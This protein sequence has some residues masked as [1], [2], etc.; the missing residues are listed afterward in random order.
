MIYGIFVLLTED[1]NRLVAFD[2]A[3]MNVIPPAWA[4]AFD[5]VWSSCTMEHAGSLAQSKAFFIKSA[6]LLRP[7]GV[8]IHTTELLLSDLDVTLDERHTSI[9]R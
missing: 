7:G 6:D 2:H 1:F 3:D 4:G 8:T 5:F 9:W